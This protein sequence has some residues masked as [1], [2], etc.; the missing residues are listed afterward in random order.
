MDFSQIIF[1]GYKLIFHVQTRQILGDDL[2][3]ATIIKMCLKYIIN[4]CSCES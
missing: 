2:I 4:L 1:L 3:E